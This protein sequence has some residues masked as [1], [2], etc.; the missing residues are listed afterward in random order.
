MSQLVTDH[1]RLRLLDAR[2]AALYCGLYTCPRVMANIGPPLDGT[3]ATRAFAATLAHNTRDVPGHRAFAVFDR[4]DATPVGIGALMREGARAEIG[5][6]LLPAAWDGRRS[7]EVLDAL[8]VHAFVSRGLQA[9]DA[10]C[11]EGPNV[12]PSRRLLRPYGFTEVPQSLAG[13]L[14]WELRRD[15]WQARGCPMVGR[16]AVAG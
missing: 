1:L 10:V 16:V 7:H 5:L 8:L 15:A 12:R 4:V 9:V 3:R 11:R 13:T 14:R 2:D 6:M